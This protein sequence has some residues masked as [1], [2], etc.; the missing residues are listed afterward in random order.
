L[1][2]TSGWVSGVSTSNTDVPLIYSQT[3]AANQQANVTAGVEAVPLSKTNKLGKY[4][5]VPSTG[6]MTLLADDGTT[7][8]GT[9]TIT[10][11]GS[12]IYAGVITSK[13]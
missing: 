2:I 12:G 5:Y 10:A 3:S 6:V 7:V 1:G 9:D 13:E 11:S 8:L 4:T